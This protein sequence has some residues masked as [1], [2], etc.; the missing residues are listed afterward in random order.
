[1]IFDVLFLEPARLG[2]LIFV[3]M[4]WII[5]QYAAKRRRAAT[6]AFS[7]DHPIKESIRV[8]QRRRRTWMA[9]GLCFSVAM[10]IVALARPAWERIPVD[11]SGKGRDVLF[12]LD[13]SNSMLAEDVA[14]NRLERAK[15]AI[16]DCLSSLEGDRVGLVIFAGSP[17][18]V[19]P[20]T[21]DYAFFKQMLEEATPGNVSQGGTRIGDALRKTVDK[22]LSDERKGLQD[23]LLISDGGDQESRPV[24]AAKELLDRGVF[25]V[26][27]GV[28]DAV[29]GARIPL[30][31]EEE[32]A[33]GRREF[34]RYSGEEVWSRL[35]PRALKDMA[36]VANHWVY[37]PA[38]TRAFQ[39]GEV[40]QDLL[41]HVEDNVLESSE[42]MLQYREEFQWFLAFGLLGLVIPLVL[43]QLG[44]FQAV[45]GLVWFACLLAT[46]DVG[47]QVLDLEDNL[48]AVPPQA[49][50]ERPIEVEEE[51]IS[52]P[53]VRGCENYDANRFEAA[54]SA[55]EEV[56]AIDGG[57]VRSAQACYNL[58][59]SLFRLAQEV[60][61]TS[62]RDALSAYTRSV[63]AYATA[64]RRDEA[65]QD[66]AWNLELARLRLRELEEY[67]E[68]N[69]EQ[70][71]EEEGEEQSKSMTE[72]DSDEEGEEDFDESMDE[73]EQEGEGKPSEYTADDRALNLDDRN[74]P[75]PMVDPE[76]IFKE[77]E[78]NN[79]VRSKGRSG[80]QSVEKDW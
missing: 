2:L 40:Y 43:N 29:S 7:G 66:A 26:T 14:P 13:V 47:G 17:S 32:Q 48:N 27:I 68:K 67:I 4:L 50:D 58:G 73:S 33:S 25:L 35:E 51:M 41:A 49:L 39:L 20:F 5:F 63:R 9:T 12:L 78:A 71:D 30:L 52:D 6:A 64:V 42:T 80:Y 62:V 70:S 8:A 74:L 61:A 59:N 31:S 65:F 69:M 36:E 1:M 21:T 22:L 53:F 3:P 23:I 75:P 46:S 79:E 76:D 11:A 56:L 19:C 34:L 37:L 24:E 77:Q 44:R 38:G 18:I 57:A 72:E 15:L 54:I 45:G 28:G 60:E 10:A 16:L 55:F